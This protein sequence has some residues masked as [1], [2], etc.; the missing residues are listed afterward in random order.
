MRRTLSAMLLVLFA[1]TAGQASV[2]LRFHPADQHV[3]TGANGTL[4]VMVDEALDIRTVELTVTYDPAI[5]TSI[6][7]DPGQLF[8][9]SGCSLFPDFQDGTPGEWYGACVALGFDCWVT[10]PGELYR[11]TFNGTNSGT[12]PIT[13]IQVRLYDPAANVIADV[14]LPGTVV[15]VG[16]GTASPPPPAPGLEL[17]LAP[18]PFNPSCQITFS[19][20][21]PGPA[22]LEVFDLAGRHL[23]TPWQGTLDAGS[24]S[25][26][27]QAAAAD[28]RPLASGV[29]LFRLTDAAGRSLTRRGILL[30]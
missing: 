7:G 24:T 9:S 3:D 14:T 12:S 17:N 27:W 2:E 21:T 16:E 4:S 18:N 15:Y 25:F 6:D 5:L 30:K 1:A 19:A 29:Y 13:A 23:A 8:L 26:S 22:R 11:W 28:G 20:S 10:G